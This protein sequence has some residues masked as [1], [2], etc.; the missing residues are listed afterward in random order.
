MTRADFATYRRAYDRLLDCAASHA[1]KQAC[2][3][4]W[5]RDADRLIPAS[6]GKLAQTLLDYY[7]DGN[8]RAAPASKA[9][10]CAG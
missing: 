7:V 4:G 1:A 10:L 9:P 6:D 5:M 8:L 2:I 3:D